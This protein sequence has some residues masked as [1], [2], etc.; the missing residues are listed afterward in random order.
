[1]PRWVRIYLPL[2]AAILACSVALFCEEEEEPV[3][4]AAGGVLWVVDQPN[5]AV[6]ILDYDGTVIYTVGVFPFFKKPNCVDVDG[7]D[8]SAWVLDYY[9]NKLRKFDSYGNLVY[10]TPGFEAGEPLILRGT[11][12]AVDQETGACWVADRSHDRVL[13]V[14]EKGKVLATVTGFRAPRAVS[15]VPGVGDCWVADELNDRVL[16]LPADVAGKVEADKVKLAVTAGLGIPYGVAADATGGAWV[17]DREVR[18]VVKLTADGGRAAEITGFDWP[19]DVACSS[20]AD[21]VFV[22]DYSKGSLIAFSRGVSGTRAMGKVAKLAVEG[23]PSPTDVE[24]DE[25]GGYVFVS[26]SDAV[27]RYTASGQL[28]DTYGDLELPVTV[29]ADPGR[30]TF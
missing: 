15:V 19:Y 17:I 3:P 21:T 10:E 28:L 4:P 22:V 5:S 14:G 26:A 11:S 24:L 9:V 18:S 7:R 12:I 13:K 8:G 25:E 23:L 29:A 27:R 6:K 30:G 1:M 2:F 20:G 16:K